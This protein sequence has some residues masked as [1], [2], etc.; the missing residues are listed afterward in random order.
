MELLHIWPEAITEQNGLLTVGFVLEDAQGKRKPGWYRLPARLRAAITESCDPFVVASLFIA[1]QT[2]ATLRVHGPVSASLLR[3]LE[4]FQAIWH[5][6]KPEKYLPVE[7]QAESEPEAARPDGSPA[8]MAFSGGLDS[9]FTAWR[10]HTGQA[11]RLT[12]DL[13]A[14]VVLHGFDIPINREDAFEVGLRALAPH[15]GQPGDGFHPDGYQPAR[16]GR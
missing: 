4:E 12:E 11:G 1:M 13:Q 15:A 14:G 5:T 8:V 10:H 9:S 6:W 16:L 7:I 3:N 2:P